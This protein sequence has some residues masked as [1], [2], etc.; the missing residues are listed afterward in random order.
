MI[1]VWQQTFMNNLKFDFE[2]LTWCLFLLRVNISKLN[3]LLCNN[4]TNT[5][6]LWELLNYFDFKT[7]SML[8][9]K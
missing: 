9:H 7:S 2:S 8:I 1:L 3:L 6:I 5:T 4:R